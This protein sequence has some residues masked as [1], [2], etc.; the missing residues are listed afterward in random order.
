MSADPIR[1]K[2]LKVLTG[3]YQGG[4][5]DALLDHTLER[6]EEPQ[7]RAFLAELVLGTLQWRARYQHILTQFIKRKMPADD[8]L[9][10]LLHLS[11]H[12]LV[13]QDGV[14]AFAALH[15][16]GE[17]C[18]KLVSPGKV[19]FV[20]GVLQ[21]VRRR[22]I[23]DDGGLNQNS[24]QGLFADLQEGGPEH[25]A[26]WH[27][28][29]VW[30]VRRWVERFGSER[31]AA[32]LD[33]NNQAV[34]MAF[35]VLEPSDPAIVSKALEAWGIAHENP[36]G[37]RCLVATERPPRA[38][39]ARAL[40]L[41]PR[42]IVQDPVV[43]EATGWL[44]SGLRA[45][46]GA[47]LDMCAAPGGKT[48]RLAAAWPQA[49]RIVAMDNRPHRVKMLQDTV[50]R[51]DEPRIDVLESDGLEAPFEPGT[52]DAVL[53][54]GP[55][56]GTGVLRHH[57][58]GRWQLKKNTPARN[59]RILR[60]LAHAAADLVAPGGHLLYATCSLEVHENERVIAKLLRERD[61]LDPLP[62]AA[63]RWQR[64][65]LPGEG[66]WAGDGFFAARLRRK[67]D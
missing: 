11:L 36:A 7:D 56:S 5:L 17:L 53:L 1:G 63:G 21:A 46:Q 57:P 37:S 22:V 58:D 49:E 19:G 40:E 64:L 8:R 26:A 15:Q 23:A 39:V 2:A 44:L 27:S 12:Q 13:G 14:P 55:C 30:L 10:A 45:P 61:D 50:G 32:M 66:A 6:T 29:P 28:F 65:W 54:D 47:V 18:R 48:A 35:H 59:G 20:N 31:T 24:L 9:Q 33:F 62:D 38:A 52:F 3:V 41:Q 60:K 4:H 25:L 43:Q 51:I 16:A 42:L 34:P 67:M